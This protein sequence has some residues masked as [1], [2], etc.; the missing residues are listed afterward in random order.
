[1]AKDTH[2]PRPRVACEISAERVVAARVTEGGSNLE[3]AT[4]ST[5]PAGLVTPGLQAGEHRRARQAGRRR[6]AIRLRRWR[7]ARATSAW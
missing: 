3:A 1:M 6:C 2:I 4:A 5:L 7:D